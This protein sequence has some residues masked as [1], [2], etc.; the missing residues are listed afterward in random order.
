[1]A[2]ESLFYILLIERLD[3]QLVSQ[4]ILSSL[5]RSALE[6]SS[7]VIAHEKTL[8]HIIRITKRASAEASGI[9]FRKNQKEPNA[10]YFFRSLA[11]PNFPVLTPDEWQ[12]YLSEKL[13]IPQSES[14]VLIEKELDTIIRRLLN[15][16]GKNSVDSTS[17]PGSPER[18]L[19]E[20]FT[21]FAETF[22]LEPRVLR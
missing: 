16:L 13:D 6:D 7:K 19:I 2:R 14:K 17:A 12:E 10:R 22:V 1:M 8:I 11:L 3:L 5:K 20:L 9:T 4:N 15:H 21:A 18:N